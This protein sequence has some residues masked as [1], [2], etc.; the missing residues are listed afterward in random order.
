MNIN[1]KIIDALPYGPDFCFVDSIESVNENKIVGKYTYRKNLFFH[2]SHFKDQ[3]LV[4]GV[5]MVETMGQIGMVCH[6]IY[7]TDDYLFNFMPVLSNIE[8]DFYE[9]ANYDETLIIT[10]N[11]IYFRHSILKSSVE[12]RKSDNSLVARLTA[13]IKIIEKK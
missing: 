11:K 7:L 1:K 13:N 2:D 6:L 4:P 5:I 3:P 10:G 12:M 9:N 8:V